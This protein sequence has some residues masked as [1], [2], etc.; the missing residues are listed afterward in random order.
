MR[1]TT[2]MFIGLISIIISSNGK[3]ANAQNDQELLLNSTTPSGLVVQ[4]N[5]KKDH[6]IERLHLAQ[7]NINGEVQYLAFDYVFSNKAF[8]NLLRTNQLLAVLSEVPEGVTFENK[9]FAMDNWVAQFEFDPIQAIEK[10]PLLIFKFTK[11]PLTELVEKSDR[12][13]WLTTGNNLQGLKVYIDRV[14][15]KIVDAESFPDRPRPAGLSKEEY[16]YLK[17]SNADIEATY[18][19][20]KNLLEDPNWMGVIAL[21]MKLNHQS[22]PSNLQGL[23]TSIEQLNWDIIAFGVNQSESNQQQT[24]AFGVI[25]YET[26]AS[27]T[28]YGNPATTSPFLFRH[29]L[30][31][32]QN[33]TL[34]F[35]RFQAELKSDEVTAY[36]K[37]NDP[38]FQLTKF[39]RKKKKDPEVYPIEGVMNSQNGLLRSTFWG[40]IDGRPIDGFLKTLKPPNT[41]NED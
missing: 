36:W 7:S 2:A 26:P 19:R 22:L 11:G 8:D 1:I 21:N 14:N 29:F 39:N 24:K 20:V 33:S 37:K 5:P 31:L 41:I 35:A 9:N 17:E 4:L 15:Q 25:D 40:L 34:E 28:M 27:K 16:K 30:V 6:R 13:S 38:N 12:S 18:K 10:R 23:A 32:F 3:K